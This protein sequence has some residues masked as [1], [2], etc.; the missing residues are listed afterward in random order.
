MDIDTQLQCL[1]ND[2]PSFFTMSTASLVENYNLEPTKAAHIARQGYMFHS[3]LYAQRC[4]I[5]FAFYSRGFSDPTYAASRDLCLQSA[6]LIIKTESQ[7]EYADLRRGI[8]YKF[9]GLL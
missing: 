9:I 6:R 7:I 4:K 3:M 2:I 8:R 1:L 5:H